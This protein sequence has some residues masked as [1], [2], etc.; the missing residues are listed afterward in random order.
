[1]PGFQVI[2]SC[3]PFCILSCFVKHSFLLLSNKFNIRR[4]S[5]IRKMSCT[6]LK[7]VF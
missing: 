3:L 4:T 2:A 7:Y 1:M 6:A 5:G